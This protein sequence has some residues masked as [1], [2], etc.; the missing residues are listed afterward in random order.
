MIDYWLGW[1]IG[2]FCGWVLFACQHG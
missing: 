2:V 1:A